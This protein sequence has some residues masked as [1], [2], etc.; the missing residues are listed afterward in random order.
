MKI[1]LQQF[2][3]MCQNRQL[4][5]GYVEGLG[6]VYWKPRYVISSDTTSS[7]PFSTP[8]YE[9]VVVK[10]T[11][12]ANC[13]L[14]PLKRLMDTGTTAL[15]LYGIANSFEQLSQKPV[16][17]GEKYIQINQQGTLIKNPNR[18]YTTKGKIAAGVG[19]KIFIAGVIIDAGLYISGE[20]TFSEAALNIGVNTGIYLIGLAYPPAGIVLGILW[21]I[22]SFSKSPYNPSPS[23]EEMHGTIAPADATRVVLPHY[24]EPI[25][26]IP[27]NKSYML[28]QGK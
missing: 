3:Q 10:D 5:N 4:Y 23:Y 28:N 2:E 27:N 6:Y 20:Q 15:S 1:T 18:V 9:L 11:K 13:G 26:H 24:C 22:T 16:V 25:K 12:N 17:V 21:F 8:F 14:K 19:R 7:E